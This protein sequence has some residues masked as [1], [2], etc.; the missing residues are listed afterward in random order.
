MLEALATGAEQPLAVHAQAA[1]WRLANEEQ[2]QQP[3]PGQ[4]LL[5]VVPAH[6]AP[7]DLSAAEF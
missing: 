3:T 5:M 4:R 2:L 1:L 7:L 6:G